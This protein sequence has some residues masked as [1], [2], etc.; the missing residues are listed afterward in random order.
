MCNDRGTIRSVAMRA[1]IEVLCAT[2][3]VLCATIE[4]LRATIEVLR[5]TRGTTCNER[6]CAQR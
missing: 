3:E 6:Y 5:A 4:V 2:M 1:T